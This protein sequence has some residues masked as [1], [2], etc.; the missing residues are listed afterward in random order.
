MSYLSRNK[1][2]EKID[3]QIDAK[4]IYIFCEGKD[5]EVK[6]FNFFQGLSSNIDII[7]IPNNNGKSDPV[8]LKENADLIFFGDKENLILPQLELNLEYKDQVWFVIDTDRWNEGNKIEILKDFCDSK[9]IENIN[10]FVVQSNPCFE[11]WYFYHFYE[12]M[13]INEDVIKYISFKDFV[14]NKIKGGFDNRKMPI[15]LTNAIENS[16]KNYVEDEQNMQPK[17]YS[18]QMH[19]LGIVI[20]SFVKEQLKLAKEMMSKKVL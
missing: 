19:H 9:N 20:N 17:L 14:N 6:Y 1:I 10:W 5:T 16:L 13:P 11:L 8:K 15:E 18:T 12:S 2:S 3:A 4:K 7:P